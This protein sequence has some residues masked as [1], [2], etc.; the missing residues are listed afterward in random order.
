M[1]SPDDLDARLRAARAAAL[2]LPPLPA[3]P[4]TVSLRTT[5]GMV[6]AEWYGHQLQ[7]TTEELGERLD[8]EA[9]RAALRDPAQRRAV[10]DASTPELTE[11]LERLW[12]RAREFPEASGSVQYGTYAIQPPFRAEPQS[13]TGD[14]IALDLIRGLLSVGREYRQD[15]PT[16]LR[17]AARLEAEDAIGTAVAFAIDAGDRELAATLEALLDARDPEGG[18]STALLV[19]LARQR[20]PAAHERLGALLLGA[21]RQEGLRLEILRC[22]GEGTVG[23]FSHILQLVVDHGLARLPSVVDVLGRWW[24][25][26]EREVANREA[27][28]ALLTLLA[29]MLSGE[30]TSDDALATDDGRRTALWAAAV[31]GPAEAFPLIDRLLADPDP[32]MRAAALQPLASPG[33]P[34]ARIPR[35][36]SALGDPEPVIALW[37]IGAVAMTTSREGRPP[38]GPAGVELLGRMPGKVTHVR[39]GLGFEAFDRQTGELVQ[40]LMDEPGFPA[41]DAVV[42]RLAD[43]DPWTR[44]RLVRDHGEALAERHRAV[45]LSLL[46][47]ASQP[48]REAAFRRVRELELTDAEALALEPLLRRKAG[49]LR[50]HVLALIQSRGEAW[51]R[52]A[53]GRLQAAGNAQLRLA[54]A[55]LLD[56]IGGAAEPTEDDGFGLFDPAELT[57]PVEPIDRRPN[58]LDEATATLIRRLGEFA[59]AHAEDALELVPL[60]EDHI[61]PPYELTLAD[62]SPGIQ[63]DCDWPAWLADGVEEVLGALEASTRATALTQAWLL[64]KLGLTT[65]PWGERRGDALRERA[66]GATKLVDRD[67]D[68]VVSALVERAVENSWTTERHDWLLDATEALLC[69]PLEATDGRWDRSI[70]ITH[71][72]ILALRAALDRLA[73]APD[74][75]TDEQLRRFWGL[76]RWFAD[77]ADPATLADCSEHDETR[78]HRSARIPRRLGLPVVDLMHRQGIAT[79]ADVLDEFIGPRTLSPSW[80]ELSWASGL[81]RDDERQ[82]RISDGVRALAHRAR[83]RIVEIELGRGEAPT[84]ATRAVN[85]LSHTGGL[86]VCLGALS[87]LRRDAFQ[88]GYAWHDWSRRATFSEMVRATV[89]GEGE[90]PEEFAARAAEL[91]LSR[92]RLL[93]LATYAPQWA[94]HVEVALRRPGLADAVWWVHAHT[95]DEQWTVTPAIRNLWRDEIGRR[96]E[97]SDDD[98]TAGAV[99]VGWFADVRAAIGP[100]G[101]EEVLS[102]A[103]YASSGSGHKRAELF[104]RA[105]DGRA[106]LKELR[107]AV[108]DR[109]HQD[110][111]RALGLRP[112]SPRRAAADLR[113]RYDLMQTF[114]RESRQFGSQRQESERSAVEIGLAN[115]A[116]TAGYRDP[117]R[118]GWAMEA[119][120]TA[121][122][123]EGV[124]ITRDDV[125]IQLRIDAEGSPE[126]RVARGERSLKAIPAALRKDPEIRALTARQREVRQ[127]AS[128]IRA[129][130]EQAMVRGDAF[131]GEELVELR[132]HAALWPQLRELVLVHAHG[133]L[134]R[135]T[136]DA[137]ALAP[138]A[139]DPEPLQAEA[140]VRIAHPVD[141]L[142]EGRWPLWQRDAL[143]NERTQPFKQIFRELYVAVADEE[144]E[145]SP[146]TSRR[147][148]GHQVK[149]RQAMA[150]LTS[151]GW[152][153]EPWAPPTRTLRD[154]RLVVDVE[155]AEAWGT[156]LEVMPPVVEAVRFHRLGSPD[157]IT[158]GEVDPRIFSEIMRDLDLVVS[159][160]H[161]G[162]VDPEASMSTIEARAALVRETAALLGLGGVTIDGRRALIQGR[163][164]QYAVHLGSGVVTRLPGGALCI[165]PIDAQYRGRVFLPF[166]DDDP[167][168]AEVLSKVL[169]LVRDDEIR[170]PSIRVQLGI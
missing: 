114:L 46:S 84:R 6:W 41:L 144:E 118:L 13:D 63:S 54:G 120:A 142:N 43:L 78:E 75:W 164:G 152:L 57:A 155:I 112:L 160:A 127:A 139:G 162:E 5:L 51:A 130:L 7:G 146:G 101:L 170:D 122:L 76:A 90:A 34:P 73:A 125:T 82:P 131:S 14:E 159:V 97:L 106:P 67:L 156:P 115:L 123:V 147:Y 100:K 33:L 138:V 150:L 158:L 128:R 145:R 59:R 153:C 104:A 151:R 48:V 87:A 62:L 50:Q 98:L 25:G 65:T 91:G 95:K 26:G 23:C 44:R 18:W 70:A 133:T 42:A 135:L 93:Q 19:A 17:W 132:A 74:A 119:A 69:V 86:S 96:T 8:D 80:R 52:D 66:I 29:R 99:D 3:D 11:H 60:A 88:R 49:D 141:L 45:L 35:L 103:K 27:N 92:D 38:I 109:R 4:P 2:D 110:S 94:G 55:D 31:H 37:V 168:S 149:A 61:A 124:T 79:D 47:D 81:A 85:Q 113:E 36:V 16:L 89:P 56:A 24:Y 20:D 71:G 116:R 28:A 165:V 53:A 129:G 9:A 10:F 64:G 121:D 22:A 102:A 30:R 15:L 143:A 58:F 161:A 39:A 167:R 154:E 1:L 111:L 108:V 12:Q 72:R 83:D 137:R 140:S 126:L 68:Q 157:P 117:I 77:V 105:L 134:G 32:A 169:L 166:A 148:A 136:D 107:A 40:L 163:L 21:G